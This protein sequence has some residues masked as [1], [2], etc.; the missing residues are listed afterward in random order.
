MDFEKLST[1]IGNTPLVET[2]IAGVFAKIEGENPAGSIKDRAAFF[3]LKNAYEKGKV[4]LDTPIIEATSGNTG[5]GLAYCARE[6][7]LKVILTM[8]ESMSI[9]RR[10]MLADF[11]A[12]LVLT[13]AG[14]GMQGAYNKAEKLEKELGGFFVKQFENEDNAEAHFLTTAPEVF[15]AL[16][17]TKWIVAGIG[18]GGTTMGFADYIKTNELNCK[19]CGVE[20]FK[21]PLLTKGISGPHGIQG[22]G[23]NF[24]PKL[25]DMKKLDCILDVSDD[26][27]LQYTKWF[28]RTSGIKVGISSGAVLAAAELLREKERGKIVAILADNGDRYPDSLYEI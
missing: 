27:A 8:P 7:G 2:N 21:S 11:G 6:L 14:E 18:S 28:Y 10:Q 23:A 17:E 16:P 12:Q 22:I 19:V 5:I 15:R 1:K 9:E 3:M 4:T 26:D 13:P 20:P 24:I 25:I